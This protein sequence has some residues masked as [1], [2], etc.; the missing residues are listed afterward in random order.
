[1]DEGG[2][3]PNSSTYYQAIFYLWGGS[4]RDTEE[5]GE[6]EEKNLEEVFEDFNI[7]LAL[8]LYIEQVINQ[9]EVRKGSEL[10]KHG[11]S[12]ARVCE[13][14]G[15]SHWELMSYVGKTKIADY[16]TETFDIRKR[17]DFVR[18]LFQ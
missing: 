12:I 17:I 16:G 14:M 4:G 9:A 8:K 2:A 1:M 11:L 10:Y 3:R 13:L 15:V 5:D 7:V 6:E 18:S